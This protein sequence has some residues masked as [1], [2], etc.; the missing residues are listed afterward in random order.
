[1]DTHYSDEMLDKFE[2]FKQGSFLIF[3]KWQAFRLA[4]DNNPDLLTIYADEERTELEIYSTLRVL[5]S[6]IDDEINKIN[7]KAVI[8]M[9]AEM[10]YDFIQAYFQIEMEDKSEF[11][12]SRDIYE[13]H[14]DIF[15]EGK[16]IFFEKLKQADKEY[17]SN[18]S[19]D[20]P[21]TK[22]SVQ[23]KLLEAKIDKMDI[24]D[25]DEGTE[26]ENEEKE[27]KDVNGDNNKEFVPDS[28]G[29][30]E[31][32]KS[33]G[34]KVNNFEM[35]V[36]MDLNVNKTEEENVPDAD[37]FVEVQKNKKKK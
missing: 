16:Y 31:V 32:K 9:I 25:D 1:M 37:G 20:F 26:S 24:D 28:D 21:I 19:I 18:F 29:F 11:F 33:K 3:K 4:L 36:D 35:D 13:L 23:T 15:K 30:V 14:G 8:N 6:D 17:K 5:L 22:R 12:I 10:L 7:S 27:E 2:K 34:K